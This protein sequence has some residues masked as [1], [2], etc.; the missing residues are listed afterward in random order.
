MVNPRLYGH[1]FYK[2]L[3]Q[4]ICVREKYTQ[5]KIRFYQYIVK[6]PLGPYIKDSSRNGPC[7]LIMGQVAEG[8]P[9]VRDSSEYNVV[10]N[11]LVE[12]DDLAKDLLILSIPNDIL[13]NINSCETAKDLWDEIV[14]QMQGA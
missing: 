4:V 1:Y 5:L 13:M 3:R 10:E 7:P 12:A 9:Y 6:Q 14:K 8:P 2:D 11:K